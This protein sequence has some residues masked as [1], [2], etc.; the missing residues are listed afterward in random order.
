MA[1]T[2][3]SSNPKYM[4]D[5][6]GINIPYLLNRLNSYDKKKPLYIAEGETDAVTLLQAGYPVIRYPRGFGME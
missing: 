3:K 5:G 2:G 4:K 6:K 1:Y